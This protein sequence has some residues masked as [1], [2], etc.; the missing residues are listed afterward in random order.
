LGSLENNGMLLL[1]CCAPLF[2]GDARCRCWRWTRRRHGAM[3]YQARGP[4]L[5]APS[6]HFPSFV[7]GRVAGEEVGHF[8]LLHQVRYVQYSSYL[9]RTCQHHKSRFTPNIIQIYSLML[10]YFSTGPIIVYLSHLFHF[11][12][13]LYSRRPDRFQ[14][15]H[16]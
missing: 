11:H 4:S 9:A 16:P 5:S 15:L 6:P 10:F 13:A 12:Y 8:T 2:P 14:A 3:T 1:C 7:P